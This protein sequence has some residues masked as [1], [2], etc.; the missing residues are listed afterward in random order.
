MWLEWQGTYSGALRFYR[1]IPLEDIYPP[2]AKP[3]VDHEDASPFG[4]VFSVGTDDG[5]PSIWL[6]IDGG[7]MHTTF[8]PSAVRPAI[9]DRATRE[10]AMSPTI[11]TVSP[12]RSKSASRP[13]ASAIV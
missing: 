3:H 12:D 13:C 11:A 4:L 8:A 6:R 2:P 9:P 5:L 1:S 10:L 7:P